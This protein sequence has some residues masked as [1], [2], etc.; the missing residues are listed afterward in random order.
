M[1]SPLVIWNV[2]MSVVIL[3]FMS[4]LILCYIIQRKAF[5]IAQRYP[6]IVM[7]EI[8]CV[9]ISGALACLTFAF[10][11]S[12]FPDCQKYQISIQLI[13]GAS[14]ASFLL[15]IH[16]LFMKDFST[17]LLVQQANA[18]EFSDEISKDLK[19]S[20]KSGFLYRSMFSLLSLEM[21]YLGPWL[22]GF[23]HSFPIVLG[24][25]ISCVAVFLSQSS[26]YSADCISGGSIIQVYAT[27][28]TYNYLLICAIPVFVMFRR[29]KDGLYLVLELR[30]LVL[31]IVLAFLGSLPLYFTYPELLKWIDAIENLALLC[32]TSI[33]IVI[34]FKVQAPR[35]NVTK[36]AQARSVAKVIE[37][38]R[39]VIQTPELRQSFLKHL[40]IEYS[41]ENLSFYEVCFSVEIMI[42][43]SRTRDEIREKILFIRNNFLL[44]S[45]ISCVNISRG[46]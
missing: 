30:L 36:E 23:L 35:K 12:I 7:F 14:N 33:P 17:K 38:L 6:F 9:G 1:S 22:A 24:V 31:F 26:V 42:Q 46:D 8:A 5:P 2:V 45:A 10:P 27:L 37:E 11:F 40:E 43:Q 4:I 3:V 20:A 39:F 16:C 15:R 21:K 25:V 28:A 13:T 41:V 32:I 34:S 18:D 19:I 29:M 44:T